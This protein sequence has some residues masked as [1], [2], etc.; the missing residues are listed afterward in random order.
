MSAQCADD[1]AA[2]NGHH[3]AG[4]SESVRQEEYSGADRALEQMNESGEI[5]AMVFINGFY[6]YYERNLPVYL[7]IS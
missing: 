4:S 7:T 5:S 3:V 1:D 2:N 6:Q